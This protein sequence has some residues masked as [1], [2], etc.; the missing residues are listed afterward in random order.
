MAVRIKQSR[1]LDAMMIPPSLIDVVFLLLIFFLLQSYA[2]TDEQAIP[3]DLPQATAAPV[4]QQIPPLNVNI[5]RAGQ[6]IVRG[7]V[8]DAAGLLA[9]FNEVQGQNPGR[10]K[11][12]IRADRSVNVQPVVTVMELCQRASIRNYEIATVEAQP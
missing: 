2:E 11:V 4:T 7:N 3:L 10:V 6:Y 5:N 12:L 8:V 9:I 1:A